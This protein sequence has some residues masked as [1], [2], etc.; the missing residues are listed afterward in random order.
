MVTLVTKVGKLE[1]EENLEWGSVWGLGGISTNR[2]DLV[3]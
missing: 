1:R 2:I 3:R